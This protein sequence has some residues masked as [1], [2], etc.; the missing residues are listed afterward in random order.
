MVE[1]TVNW[2]NSVEILPPQLFFHPQIDAKSKIDSE[3]NCTGKKLN[4]PKFSHP[5]Q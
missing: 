2:S 1:H 4:L 5:Q 3:L